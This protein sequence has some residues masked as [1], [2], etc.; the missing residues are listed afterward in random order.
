[1]ALTLTS[2][3]PVKGRTAGRRLVVLT[4][5]DFDEPTEI[6]LT[7]MKV[8]FGALQ[9]TNVKVISSTS[10]TCFTPENEPGKV[11]VEVEN[12]IVPATDTLTDGYEYERLDLTKETG[13]VFIY[14]ALI[15]K[16]ARQLPVEVAPFTHTDFDKD[17]G[18]AFDT[19]ELATLPGIVLAGP[20]LPE[21]RF[22]T[23]NE[24]RFIDIGGG[25]VEIRRG[26]TVVDM[27][28]DFTLVDNQ[29]VRAFILGTA[30]VRFFH[31]NKFLEVNI[32]DG[33]PE[34]GQVSYEMEALIDGN[35]KFQPTPSNSNIITARGGLLI[36]GVPLEDDEP[37]A[38]EQTK[39]VD[40]PII[41][42]TEVL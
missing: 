4:G 35:P 2:V 38:F 32:V 28:I 11:D 41:E 8:K 13:L 10:A 6:I 7:P 37:L 27:E 14:R 17:T 15:D 39:P 3:S 25:V 16:L 22:Q 20:R 23:S 26:H 24:P 12:L 21:N 40:D 19:A 36:R 29:P 9:A 5:V 1:M 33:S 42:P 30:M 18:D 34:L 31:E